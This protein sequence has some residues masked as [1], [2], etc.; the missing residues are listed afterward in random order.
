MDM[1]IFWWT[2]AYISN[3]PPQFSVSHIHTHAHAHSIRNLVICNLVICNLVICN[4]VIFAKD[5]N[6]KHGWCY[7]GEDMMQK[8]KLLAASCCKSR[9]IYNVF[10]KMDQKYLFGLH[11][12]FSADNVLGR[13]VALMFEKTKKYN[14]VYN[15]RRYEN[16]KKP[17][18][19]SLYPCLQ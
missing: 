17:C 8:A 11:H 5:L 7:R 18:L 6:P 12:L 2:L 14:L 10:E 19:V 13:W 16:A 3:A 1:Y 15:L 4:L 9:T